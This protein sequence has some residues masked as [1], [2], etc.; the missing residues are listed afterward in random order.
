MTPGAKY[1]VQKARE[2]PR[3]YDK[4]CNRC[5]RLLYRGYLAVGSR[6]RIRCGNCGAVLALKITDQEKEAK[7]E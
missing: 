6:L 7:N 4:H 1:E 5:G 2:A 3:E